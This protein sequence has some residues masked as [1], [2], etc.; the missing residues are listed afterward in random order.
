MSITLCSCNDSNI[1]ITS[2]LI[3][4][5]KQK[6]ILVT[7]TYFSILTRWDNGEIEK[8]SPWDVEPIPDDGNEDFLLTITSTH[9]HN[10]T[11]VWSLFLI[12]LFVKSLSLLCSPAA[13]DE[14][15]W[16]LCDSR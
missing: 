8:L 5:I 16:H 1:F 9:A 7:A 12:S 2:V 15:R 14:R 6:H 11:G 4:T 10:S 13:R 3:I